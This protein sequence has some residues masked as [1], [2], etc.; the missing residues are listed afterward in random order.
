MYS[1][2]AVD[3]EEIKKAKGFI[4]ML[5][6]KQDI[7]NLLMVGLIKTWWNIKWHEFKVICIEMQLMIIV[8]FLSLVLMIKDNITWWY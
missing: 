7:K 6:K 1:L 3:G 4:N 2:I 8:K 5:L